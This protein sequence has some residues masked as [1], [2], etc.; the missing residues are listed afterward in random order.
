M[1]SEWWISALLSL[2]GGAGIGGLYFGGLW[3][4][5]QRMVASRY[6]MRWIVGSFVLRAAVAAF[7]FYWV[8][9]RHWSQLVFCLAGFMLARF[10]WLC[11]VGANGTVTPVRAPSVP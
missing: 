1:I 5:V 6:A 3:W 2:V 11:A 4:T 10:C 8:G 7:G 9:G